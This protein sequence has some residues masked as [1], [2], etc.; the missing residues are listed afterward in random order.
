[1]RHTEDLVEVSSSTELKVGIV[2][3]V[4]KIRDDH[5]YVDSLA[6]LGVSRR[7]WLRL[8]IAGTDKDCVKNRLEVARN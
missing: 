8:R 1:M 3:C 2:D 6:I 4:Q 5:K 7:A